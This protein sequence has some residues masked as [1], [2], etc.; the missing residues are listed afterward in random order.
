MMCAPFNE[1]SPE[2]LEPLN[3]FLILKTGLLM[4]RDRESG[5]CVAAHDK[6]D[7]THGYI[8]GK[9]SLLLC[10]GVFSVFTQHLCSFNFS[11]TVSINGINEN[12]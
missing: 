4:Q 9:V 6:Q 1:C 8:T 5:E 12:L 2:R 11:H 10:F 7:T 3:I